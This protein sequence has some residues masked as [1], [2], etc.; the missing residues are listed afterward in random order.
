METISAAN[1]QTRQHNGQILNNK[2]YEKDELEDKVEDQNHSTETEESSN[3][4]NFLS[5]EYFEIEQKLK[6][7]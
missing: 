5:K 3:L 6:S 7:M 1:D 4:L 2:T